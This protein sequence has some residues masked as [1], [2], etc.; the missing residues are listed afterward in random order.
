MNDLSFYASSAAGVAKYG[1]ATVRSRRR[2]VESN[3]RRD[4]DVAIE[5]LL[6]S[7]YRFL[8]ELVG[9]SRESLTIARG[10]LKRVSNYINALERISELVGGK[11]TNR[12]KQLRR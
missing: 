7:T 11:S 1:E 10:P 8:A 5:G 4:A 9:S 2:S 6:V 12:M 3:S